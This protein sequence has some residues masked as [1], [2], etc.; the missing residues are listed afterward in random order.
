MV[1]CYEQAFTA[2]P[3]VLKKNGLD[4]VVPLAGP[5]GD[6]SLLQLFPR[7]R[8]ETEASIQTLRV[9]SQRRKSKLLNP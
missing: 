4:W 6:P 9:L 5:E 8:G 7:W 2:R 1:F 3:D